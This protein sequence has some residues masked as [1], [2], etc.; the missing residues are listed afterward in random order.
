MRARGRGREGKKGRRERERE[1]DRQTDRQT[2]RDREGDPFKCTH[3]W[4]RNKNSFVIN[5]IS[6]KLIDSAVRT[7]N[8]K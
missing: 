8:S 2:D 5:N 1:T 4:R 3:S 7:E 6:R